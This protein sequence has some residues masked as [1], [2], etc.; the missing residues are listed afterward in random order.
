MPEI[1]LSFWQVIVNSEFYIAGVLILALLVFLLI[2]FFVF[3][4]IA[5]RIHSKKQV[6]DTV[7]MLVMVPQMAA[8][9]KAG[10]SGES[11]ISLQQLQE[12]ISVMESF[13]TSLAA[14]KAERGFVAWWR[15]RTDNLSVEIVSHQG[16][17]SFYISSP[18]KL[19]DL[20]ED[21]ITA[22]FPDAVI[23]EVVDF[24]IFS[25]DSI[26]GSRM[27]E[28]KKDFFFP[29][30]TYKKIESDPMKAVINSLSQVEDEDGVAIQIAFRSAKK[31]WHKPG[32]KVAAK[33]QQGFTFENAMKE[34]NKSPFSGFAKEFKSFFKSSNKDQGG[35]GDQ[36]EHH[37][38]SPMEQEI[39]KG[40]EEKTSKAGVDAS[41]R[42]I[43]AS[44]SQAKVDNY[45]DNIVNAFSQF[46]IYQYGNSF[47]VADKKN[48]HVVEQFIY[49]NIGEKNKVVLNTE[50]LASLF[51]FPLPGINTNPKIRWL[52][53]R[54]APPPL[55]LPTEGAILGEANYR[56][57]K[58]VIRI[59]DEDRR[60]HIYSIGKT[61][62]GKSYLMANLILQDIKA[63][64]GV[65]VMDPHG[66]LAQEIIKYIPKERAEDVI[67]F[68][69]ADVD[70]PVGMNLLEFERPEQKTFV[71]NELL[72]IFDKLYDLRSTGGPMFESYFRNAAQLVMEDPESGMT[73]MEI[74]RVLA[75]DEYRAYK[76]SKTKNPTV[77][78]FWEKEA[79]KAGGEASLANMVPYITSKLTQFIGNDY[80]RPIIAQQ[81]SAFSFRKAMDEGK[82]LLCDLAKGKIGDMNSDLLGMVIIGKLLGAALSRADMAP[83]D[84]KDF[85][86][87]IDEFQNYLTEGISI[88]LSE[89]RKYRLCLYIA[90]QFLG[91]LAKTKQDEEIRDAI[92]GN[93][94]SI[95]CYRVG[96]D[97]AEVMAKQFAPVFSEYDVMNVPSRTVF[98][99]LLVN[100]QNPP[101]FNM[102]VPQR[103]K[104]SNPEIAEAIM[105][106]SRLKYGRDRDIIESE[107]LERA[108][109]QY[110]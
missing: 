29:I 103:E 71:I 46:N 108:R 85:Y 67:Y 6:F 110:S 66:E 30:K 20:I 55:E 56:G 62:T 109:I 63:G 2:A 7:L 16:K 28:F 10:Q 91:Q 52:E 76:L 54:Q 24:N 41:I 69:P 70:R 8:S 59:A 21:Q 95:M 31:E 42:I 86:L 107:I 82:I 102:F 51:H 68:N 72:N 92:F 17:I 39:V 49:R 15:G 79:Q 64:K 38:L 25:P 84:R 4:S 94:G 97:D 65:C 88:I 98:I 90:H 50:E 100:N 18:K 5:R 36:R 106:L 73:L 101:A 27:L 99:K 104:P 75:D 37:Q 47:G 43:A 96:V 53:A 33:M 23:E 13:L 40:L 57:M 77:K 44:K 19:V 81:K 87:Y 74:P 48:K 32:A 61:G 26:V 83:E 14:L 58:R 60:R 12:K 78:D 3:R 80:M 93:I 22:Q 1:D 9:Q 11:E 35:Q 89:A 45:L 34:I 105:E